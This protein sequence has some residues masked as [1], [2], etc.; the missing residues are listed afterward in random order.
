MAAVT[1]A[2]PDGS[3]HT[4]QPTM[5]VSVVGNSTGCLGA[6]VEKPW[7]VRQ[8]ITGRPAWRASCNDDSKPASGLAQ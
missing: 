3:S 7:R 4:I 8:A 2:K 1:G 6:G 5:L